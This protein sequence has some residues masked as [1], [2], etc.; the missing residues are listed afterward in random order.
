[1]GAHTQRAETSAHRLD[2]AVGGDS[3]TVAVLREEPVARGE[4]RVR[5]SRE[6]GLMV[7]RRFDKRGSL[8]ATDNNSC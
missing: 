4:R 5:V 6:P 7:T 3:H 1:M 8:G 2:L